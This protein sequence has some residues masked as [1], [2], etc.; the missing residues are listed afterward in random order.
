MKWLCSLFFRKDHS[1][2]NSQEN[3]TNFSK[4][5]QNIQALV[6]SNMN[7]LHLVAGKLG[8]QDLNFESLNKKVENN[9]F[10]LTR[11]A[12]F[13]SNQTCSTQPVSSVLISQKDTEIAILRQLLVQKDQEIVNLR[14]ETSTRPLIQFGQQDAEITGLLCLHV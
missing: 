13:I 8:N 12:N 10:L 4:A 7:S 2:G 1:P 3:F 11:L 14:V 5:L 9:K 6:V